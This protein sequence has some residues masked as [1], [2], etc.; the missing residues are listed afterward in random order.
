[1]ASAFSLLMVAV[2]AV[3]LLYVFA[4]RFSDLFTVKTDPIPR[5]ASAVF[6]A[7]SSAGQTSGLGKVLFS[8]QSGLSGS[9]FSDSKT[10]LVFECNDPKFCCDSGADCASK[11]K[12][13]AKTLTF[14]SSVNVPVFVRC[15]EKYGFFA[16]SIFFGLKP[17]QLELSGFEYPSSFDLAV[18][19][20]FSV[21]LEVKNSGELVASPGIMTLKITKRQP[22]GA[23]QELPFKGREK[24]LNG[25][26]PNE[27]Q[28]IA[29]GPVEL[30]SP[31][32]YEIVI[33]AESDNAGFDEK[34]LPLSVTGSAASACRAKTEVAPLKIWNSDTSE[35]VT[36]FFCENC[37]LGIDC[38]DSWQQ[39]NSGAFELGDFSFAQ[40]TEIL[41]Q[42]QCR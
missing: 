27:F 30:D 9:A 28:R 5:L 22:T 23:M 24:E 8:G 37:A 25:L 41:T 35:C 12:W 4:D 11:I 7:K 29:I 1:M 26:G 6:S 38:R 31:G 18:N 16:C 14:G 32:N 17:S 42:D 10:D 39:V 21:A 15:N 20:P 33:R 40:T 36:K 34:K 3:A 13:N 19:R 2:I